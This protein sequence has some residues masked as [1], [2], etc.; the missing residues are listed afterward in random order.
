MAQA[1]AGEPNSSAAKGAAAE[2]DA[3]DEQIF[4]HK[5]YPAEGLLLP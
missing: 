1:Q 2:V 5:R 3:G 4:S